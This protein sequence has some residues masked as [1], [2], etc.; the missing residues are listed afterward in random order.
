[1][2]RA[3]RVL[4]GDDEAFAR[5]PAVERLIARIPLRVRRSLQ[6]CG[7]AAGFV[8]TVNIGAEHDAV[9]HHCLDVLLHD[10]RVG[11]DRKY[12]GCQH[13]NLLCAP[14]MAQHAARQGSRVVASFDHDLTINK[15]P[16]DAE[17]R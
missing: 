14:L 4:N 9:T 5:E 16:L 8:G 7:K 6:E 11:A 12:D 17:L 10:H 13:R 2:C 1:M 15:K 3:A